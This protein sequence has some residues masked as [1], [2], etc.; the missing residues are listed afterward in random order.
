MLQVPLLHNSQNSGICGVPLGREQQE[1]PGQSFPSV[2]WTQQYSPVS[3]SQGTERSGHCLLVCAHARMWPYIQ[4]LPIRHF[5]SCTV[6]RL[7]W[8]TLSVRILQGLCT[9]QLTTS[10]EEI[11]FGLFLACMSLN[12][13]DNTWGKVWTDQ[14]SSSSTNPGWS[15]TINNEDLS[16]GDNL[17]DYS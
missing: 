10:D 6:K 12:S 7:T 8:K 9:K 1:V 14:W 2:S 3:Y 16:C 17:L 4:L 11:P 15:G 5:P 13:W